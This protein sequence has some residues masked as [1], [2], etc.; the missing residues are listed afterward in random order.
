VLAVDLLNDFLNLVFDELPALDFVDFVDEAVADR[1]LKMPFGAARAEVGS[2]RN[3]LNAIARICR[4]VV[5]IVRFP[6]CVVVSCQEVWLGGSREYA[7][8]MIS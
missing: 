8:P 3:R 6:S 7:F 2:V 1:L 5:F 4:V